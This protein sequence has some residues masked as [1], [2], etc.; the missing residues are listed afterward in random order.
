M[1]RRV[2]AGHGTRA[3]DVSTREVSGS[4]KEMM[5]SEVQQPMPKECVVHKHVKNLRQRDPE[6]EMGWLCG[7]FGVCRSR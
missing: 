2:M 6:A 1:S 4:C 3:H 7:R 5:K